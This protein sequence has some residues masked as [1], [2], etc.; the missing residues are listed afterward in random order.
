MQIFLTILVLI[1]MLGILIATHEAGHL[2]MAKKFGVY[3]EEY[4]IGFGPKLFSHKRKGGET[5]FS[6]RAIPLGGYVSMYGEASVEPN[7]EGKVIPPERSLEGIKPWKR[8]LVLVAGI[9]VN[10]ILSFL[11]CLIYATCFPI[12]QSYDYVLSCVSNASTSE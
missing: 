10:L 6:V 12:Y 2:F 4:S 9:V 8:C 11:F 1:V 7:E 3:C 5:T